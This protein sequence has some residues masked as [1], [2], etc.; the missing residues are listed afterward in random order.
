MKSFK[1]DGMQIDESLGQP[2]KA[3]SSIC[4]SL[5][6]GSN[7]TIERERQPEKQS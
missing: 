6:P 5:E 4:E 1:D 2:A 3:Q 7:V